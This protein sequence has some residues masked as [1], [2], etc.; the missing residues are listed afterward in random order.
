MKI[1][2]MEQP[3]LRKRCVAGKMSQNMKREERKSSFK[4]DGSLIFN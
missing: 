1:V 4:K 2:T 3:T